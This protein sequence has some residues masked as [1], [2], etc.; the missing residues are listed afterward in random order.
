MDNPII[1]L[2]AGGHAKS[3]IEALRLCNKNII[4]I[5][6]VEDYPKKE[7][8][9]IPIL[10]NDDQIEKFLPANVYLVNAIG[11]T[12][13]TEH[14]KN[15]FYHFKK[16][17]YNFMDVIHPSAVVS[18][19]ATLGEGVQIMAGAIV[20]S[21]CSIGENTIINTKASLDHDC[22]IGAHVHIAPGT[23][24]SGN[25]LIKNQ[26]HIGTGAVI[27]Q[28]ICVGS[29]SLIGAGAVVIQNVESG[30]KVVGVPAKE[31]SS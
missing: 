30:K 26:V 11:S 31:I 17:G 4:G 24:L 6:T 13:T 1:I 29:N 21:D 9:G 8:K 20:Q 15:I 28:G 25:V 27:I 7:F 18:S 19:E 2:G 22:V 16:K 23:T 12:S 3:V 10:G 14:R 5:T